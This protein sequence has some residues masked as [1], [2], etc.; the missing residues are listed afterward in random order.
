[1]ERFI[2]LD[3]KM[4]HQIYV[5]S[6]T[7]KLSQRWTDHKQNCNNEKNKAYNYT[8]YTKMREVGQGKFYIEL[9]EDYS[10]ERKE[11]LLKREGEIIRDIGTLNSRI[12]GRNQ[13]QYYLD[14]KE[15]K[16]DYHK[17]WYLANKEHVKLKV[18]QHYEE[19]K[20]NY[21]YRKKSVICECGMSVSYTHKS[22]HDTTKKHIN[23]MNA[24]SSETT[25]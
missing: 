7:Q 14:N 3:V 6:T 2:Q 4:I 13:Q 17:E 16:S 15:H 20:D 21:D 5:G 18:K 9:Y 11:Q 19:N 1:M 10:C 23:L 8:I 22:R 25:N 24:K 12:E